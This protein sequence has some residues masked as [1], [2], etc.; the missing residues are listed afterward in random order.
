MKDPSNASKPHAG[1]VLIAHPSMA[2]N[3]F[4]ETLIFLHTHEE[5][6]SVG[7]ILNR[8]SGQSLSSILK[9]S[10]LPAS[11]KDLPLFYGGPVQED[12]FLLT[13]FLC[14]PDTHRFEMEVNPDRERLEEMSNQPNCGL[15]AFLGHAGWSSGQLDSELSQGDW[16]WTAPDEIMVSNQS[17]PA[18]WNLLSTGDNRWATLRDY[19]PQHPERN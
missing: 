4:S 11:F 1:D 19:L 6:G 18:L 5:E 8:P 13:L 17:T 14:D 15:R 7:L 3:L 10:E 2:E 12:H 9:D 16:L